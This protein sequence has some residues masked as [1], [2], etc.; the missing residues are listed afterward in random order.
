[1]L[2]LAKNIVL[3]RAFLTQIQCIIPEAPDEEDWDHL[4][5][6]EGQTP[7]SAGESERLRSN[8]TLEGVLSKWESTDAASPF[9]ITNYIS[10]RSSLI[11]KKIK[12]AIK[13]RDGPIPSGPS[14][15]HEDIPQGIDDIDNFLRENSAQTHHASRDSFS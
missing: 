7:R 5:D 3:E 11:Y 9:L 6:V 1:M 15:E 13:Q 8:N 14:W 12:I 10:N 4:N 2:T